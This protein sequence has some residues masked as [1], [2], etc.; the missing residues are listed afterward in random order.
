MS[1]DNSPPDRFL[2]IDTVRRASSALKLK[3][4]IIATLDA[5]LSCLPPKR[6]HDFVFASN[7]TIAFRRNGI[8]DRTIR[9]HIAELVEIGFLQRAD[10]PNRKRFVKTDMSSGCVL[11]F[12]FDLRPLFNAYD[13]ICAIAEDCV[14]QASHLSYLRTKLRCAIARTIVQDGP[15]ELV[16]NAQRAL[17]RKL[18]AEE[19]QDW[20]GSLASVEEFRPSTALDH[21]VVATEMTASD[22]QNDRHHQNSRKEHLDSEHP[23]RN[24]ALPN[25]TKPVSLSALADACPEAMS[26]LQAKPEEPSD[27]IRHAR[28]LAP[29]MGIDRTTYQAAENRLGTLGTAVAVWGLL[30]LQTKIRQLGAYFR[31][32]TT[33][34][35][36]ATFDP[37]ALIRRLSQKRGATSC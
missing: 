31:A 9:R 35:R 5:L 21:T 8:S 26:Y 23:T 18:S 16:Q 25:Q 14:R 30:E 32:V 4:P 36:S 27:V 29:M 34:K 17:R 24:E 10:S 7:A 33:G 2:L 3:A 37:W 28:T 20:L 6:N 19:L 15:I 13:Q 1:V 12:G 11:R 22:G